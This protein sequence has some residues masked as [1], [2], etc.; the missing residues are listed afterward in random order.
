MVSVLYEYLG[1]FLP[2]YHQFMSSFLAKWCFQSLCRFICCMIVFFRNKVHCEVGR[3][4]FTLGSL[5][6]NQIKLVVGFL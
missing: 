5:H 3:F 1:G 4:C 2:I 6:L